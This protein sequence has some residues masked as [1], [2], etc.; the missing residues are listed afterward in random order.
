MKRK[1]KAVVFM[2]ALLVPG[3]F[4]QTVL[5]GGIDN[6]QNFSAKYVATG[7]RNAATDS[8]DIA[9][10]NPAGIMF[11]Q[12]GLS[13]GVDAH[14]IFK[15][16]EQQYISVNP[17]GL[18]NR[19]QDEPSLIPALFGTYKSGNWG[20]F[21]SFTVSGGGG[22]VEY[23]NGNTITNDIALLLGGAPLTNQRI[24]AE[25]YYLT[26]A[27]GGSYKINDMFSVAA[28]VRYLDATKDVK[29]NANTP[30]IAGAYEEDADGWG[31]MTSVNIKPSDALLFAIRYES[32]VDL[33]FTTKV[34]G[35]TNMLGGMV[36]AAL[37]K[38]QNAKSD[39]DLPALLGLG[40]SWDV[41]DRLNLNTSFTYYFE[42]N[43]DWGGLEDKVDNSYDLA[44]SA[45][46]GFLDNLRGSIGY[47][48]TNV[49]IDAKDFGLT[50]KMSPVL[51]AHSFFCGLGYDFS[52]MIT[53][54]LGVMINFYEEETGVDAVGRPVT[55][56]KQNTAI[57]L[58]VNFKF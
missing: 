6:K 33:E 45:T 29:A 1:T 30:T 22:T 47:M 41:M 56:D 37:N 55:Y 13:L 11:Q 23:E 48:Y 31:W 38:T 53:V 9:T 25:S 57:A 34:K 27:L 58:G 24:K 14:Y 19:E 39:R 20:V 2:A 26:Y 52:E 12:D 40:A 28:G 54:D 10:Y 32:Q 5:A 49:G 7:S 46:Y 42:E 21:G 43:A 15:N 50:E 51:D 16:Y 35:S 8:V 4:S 36:L 17:P 3:V 44:V 18:V